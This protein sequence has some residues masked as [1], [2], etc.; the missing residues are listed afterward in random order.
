M[1][2]RIQEM[3]DRGLTV[4]RPL[5]KR[6][7]GTC[8]DFSTLLC[9][10]LRYQSIPARA[11][12]GFGAYFTPGQYEDHWVCEYWNVDK[13]RWVMVDAQLDKIQRS[14]L[15]IAFDPCDVP[16]DE[17]L[18]GGKAWQMC[19]AGHAGPDRFG[20]FDMHGLWFVRGNLVRDMASLN[21][22]ELLPWDTWG[23]IESRD[24][25]LSHEDMALLDHVAALTVSDDC[26]FPEVRSIYESDT[27]LRV[28][29]IIRSYTTKGVQTVDLTGRGTYD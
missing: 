16:S 23:I 20:I 22:N 7:V 8:R 21:K 19:R 10:I 17:F 11:R 29:S 3:D 15:Q 27:R 6:L 25:D 13:Q 14:A 24:D 1:L 26:A 9:A 12:C 28:S 18:T 5:E 4:V 2:S